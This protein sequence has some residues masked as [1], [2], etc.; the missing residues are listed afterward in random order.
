MCLFSFWLLYL[1]DP[2]FVMDRSLTS[3]TSAQ[4]VFSFLLSVARELRRRLGVVASPMKGDT[5]NDP[6]LATHAV[7]AENN[8]LSSGQN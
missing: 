4:L 5:Q 3:F 8:Q 2:N 6:G 1:A 7:V